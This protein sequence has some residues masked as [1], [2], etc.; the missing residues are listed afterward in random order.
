[1]VVT[2]GS[3]TL[4]TTADPGGAWSV[5][6]AVLSETSHSVQAS[7]EDAAG[8]TGRDSQDL[9]VDVTVPV[10]T[11]GGGPARSTSDTSP[12]TYGTT[13]EQAGTIV[14]VGVGGQHLTATVQPGGTWGVSAQT[15]ASGTYDVLASITDAAGNTGSITQALTVGRVTPGH[16]AGHSTGHPAGRRAVPPGRRDPSGRTRLRGPGR[17]QP[18]AP[19]GDVRAERPSRAH[20]GLL[21]PAAQPWQRHGPDH[22][23]GPPVGVPS[24]GWPICR[25][26]RTS[27]PGAGREIPERLPATRSGGGADRQGHQGHGSQDRQSPGVH[28]PW[29]LGARPPKVDA[30]AA[31]VKVFHG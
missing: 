21:G 28:G 18:V 15:L 14:N 7:V 20:R 6:A 25:G 29:P 31:V 1:M 23:S 26:A 2:V 10:L 13:A 27:R 11:I 9:T 5:H 3:Q 30:V 4:T 16:P 12:W 8:N 19:A 17:L 24:S 22:E